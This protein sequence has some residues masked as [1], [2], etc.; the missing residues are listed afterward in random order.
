MSLIS[1][2]NEQQRQAIVHE[3]GPQLIVAGAGTGKTR[4][5]TARIAYLITEKNGL[6]WAYIV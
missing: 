3:N 6:K 5:V 4:V 1:E 2:S